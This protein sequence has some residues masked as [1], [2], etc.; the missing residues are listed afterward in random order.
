MTSE[1]PQHAPGTSNATDS[2]TDESLRRA[3]DQN[4]AGKPRERIDGAADAPPGTAPGA[5]TPAVSPGG[6]PL[7]EAHERDN[8]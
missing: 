8:E 1:K 5:A 3:R 4:S 6:D 2:A 7:S